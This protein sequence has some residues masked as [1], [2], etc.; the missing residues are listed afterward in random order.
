MSTRKN[1]KDDICVLEII[2]SRAS[3]PRRGSGLRMDR[4]KKYG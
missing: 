4:R 3:P 2:D 1:H